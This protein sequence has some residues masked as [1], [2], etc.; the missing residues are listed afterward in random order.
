MEQAEI[1]QLQKE[2][3]EVKQQKDQYLAGWQRER[4]D[5]LNY[6]KDEMERIEGLMKYANAEFLLKIFPMLDNIDRAV[7]N[8]PEAERQNKTIQGF[9]MIGSQVNDFLKSQGI[10]E[11]PATGKFNPEFHEAV[12]EEQAKDKESG[13]IIEVIEKGY[14]HSGKLLRPAK[15][16]IAK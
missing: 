5:L 9:M 6:K 8:I 2:L 13:E 14:I 1:E 15:V 3:A 12:G 4:A 7:Q 11:V 16:K 10:E